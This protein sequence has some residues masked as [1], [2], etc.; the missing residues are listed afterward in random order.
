MNMCNNNDFSIKVIL[1]ITNVDILYSKQ[2]DRKQNVAIRHKIIFISDQIINDIKNISNEDV[3]QINFRFNKSGEL[4]V[5]VRLKD[6]DV[7]YS[8]SSLSSKVRDEASLLSD[9]VIRSKIFSL[10]NTPKTLSY[11]HFVNTHY[12]LEPR[13]SGVKNTTSIVEKV[14]NFFQRFFYFHATVYPTSIKMIQHAIKGKSPD[15]LKNLYI[16]AQLFQDDIIKEL[17]KNPKVK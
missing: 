10:K 4:K 17:Q 9:Y 16:D 2:V 1:N 15:E 11:H 8:L 6:K 7:D 5:V 13:V 12:Q 3:K 14:V